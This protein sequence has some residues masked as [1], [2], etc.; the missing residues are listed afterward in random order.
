MKVKKVSL[1]V[2]SLLA[3]FMTACLSMVPFAKPKK[4][5]A[6]V[7]ADITDF[8]SEEV[9]AF[10]DACFWDIGQHQSLEAGYSLFFI[11]CTFFP[12]LFECST[13]EEREEYLNYS[14]L[15]YIVRNYY[16]F[17]GWYDTDYYSNAENFAN[18]QEG[19]YDLLHSSWILIPYSDTMFLGISAGYLY[20]VDMSI[21][22]NINQVWACDNVFGFAINWLSGE[23]Y[24]IFAGLQGGVDPFADP[25]APLYVLTDEPILPGD[26]LWLI[27]FNTEYM[28]LCY[29]CWYTDYED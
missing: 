9:V 17:N 5:S 6:S 4:A 19:E 22:S 10:I 26:G 14:I 29:D 15:S 21:Q 3:A 1:Y 8:T 24:S 13:D 20:W 11:D 2:I 18:M 16:P 23:M 25:P 7:T 12:E 27:Y 28:E